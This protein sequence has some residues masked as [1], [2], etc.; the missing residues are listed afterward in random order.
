MNAK[1]MNLALAIAGAFVCS[2][3]A[4][5]AETDHE[6]R[7]DVS[8]RAGKIVSPSTAVPNTK[9][10]TDNPYWFEAHS[11]QLSTMGLMLIIR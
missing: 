9:L 7:F 10:T 11:G 3:V 1:T 4:V 5:A 2:A 6:W 8:G